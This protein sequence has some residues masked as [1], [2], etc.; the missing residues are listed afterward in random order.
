MFSPLGWRDGVH[1]LTCKRVT[2][3][4]VCVFCLI[5]CL[6]VCIRVFVVCVCA[7]SYEWLC[8][9]AR[10]WYWRGTAFCWSVCWKCYGACEF[11]GSSIRATGGCFLDF[12]M[13]IVKIHAVSRAF[14]W[15][16]NAQCL[17]RVLGLL[18]YFFSRRSWDSVIFVGKRIKSRPRN[19]ADEIYP[20]GRRNSMIIIIIIIG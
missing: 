19:V 12:D 17:T 1:A 16:V 6:C 8:V 10:V 2:L 9:S 3:L 14:L 13:K 7:C 4:F 5:V 11:T 18:I 20:L 15:I